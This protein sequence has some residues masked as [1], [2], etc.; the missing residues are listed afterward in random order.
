MHVYNVNKTQMLYW[1]RQPSVE[2]KN[3]RSDDAID[4]TH[5]YILFCHKTC[6]KKIKVIK[7]IFT[8]KM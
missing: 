5:R 6:R 2:M 8:L 1:W 3:N 4:T 7:N